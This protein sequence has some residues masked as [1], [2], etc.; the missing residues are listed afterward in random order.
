MHAGGDT[1]CEH[2]PFPSLQPSTSDLEYDAQTLT[3]ASLADGDLLTQLEGLR[4]AQERSIVDRRSLT[5][6]VRN[7]EKHC[8]SQVLE[9]R[10]RKLEQTVDSLLYSD[11]Q[12]QRL[13]AAQL[14]ELQ[15]LRQTCTNHDRAIDTMQG[16]VYGVIKPVLSSLQSD[17]A[18]LQDLHERSSHVASYTCGFLETLRPLRAAVAATFQTLCTMHHHLS[19]QMYGLPPLPPLP[20]M[21]PEPAR[22]QFGPCPYKEPVTPAMQVLQCMTQPPS[23]SSCE[24]KHVRQ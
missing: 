13:T 3:I 15:L 22:M 24:T 18:R 23:P 1:T 12:K 2:T 4:D 10:M 11:L 8:E 5:T 7:L 6:H 14:S 9:D 16:A 17:V 20:P 21:A 19:Q